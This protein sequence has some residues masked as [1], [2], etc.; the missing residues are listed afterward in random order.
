MSARLK[1]NLPDRTF[2]R[3]AGRQYKLP[4]CV[5]DCQ[6][7]PSVFRQFCKDARAVFGHAPQPGDDNPLA[8]FR[9]AVL[10]L[11]RPPFPMEWLARL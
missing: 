10:P 6:G 5:A 9:L 8:L 1:G 3:L 7:R 11:A 2:A 4:P